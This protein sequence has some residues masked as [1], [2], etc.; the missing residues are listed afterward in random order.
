MKRPIFLLLFLTGALFA[1][2]GH[3]QVRKSSDGTFTVLRPDGSLAVYGVANDNYSQG[4]QETMPYICRKYYVFSEIPATLLKK[5]AQ[6]SI[7]EL[8]ELSPNEVEYLNYVFDL[9]QFG[10]TLEGK[11]VAFL[12]GRRNYFDDEKSRYLN[13]QD[14][15]VGGSVIY[16]LDKN[17]KEASGGYDA[18][19]DSW[20][21][22]IQPTKKVIDRLVRHNKKRG[23]WQYGY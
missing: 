11:R 4:P 3:I 18:I 22:F 2:Q 17:Q 23:H 5:L 12:K 14:R 21:V 15:G 16:L 1:A 20:A 13:G 19:V 6:L 9:G 10:Y 8:S 7:T